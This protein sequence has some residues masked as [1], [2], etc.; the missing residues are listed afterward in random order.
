MAKTFLARE[1]LDKDTEVLDGDDTTRV[2]L[3]HLNLSAQHIDASLGFFGIATLGRGN[4]HGAIVFDLDS[5]TG[6]LL[7]ALDHLATRADDKTNL[8][9]RH[10]RAEKPW[11]KG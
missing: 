2:G 5:C 11:S 1:D 6:L 8:L 4:M 9:D 7:N 10:P 3:S